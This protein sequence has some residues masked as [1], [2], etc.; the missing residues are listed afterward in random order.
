MQIAN[1]YFFRF[2]SFQPKDIT[3]KIYNNPNIYF[4]IL[5]NN[6]KNPEK[7]AE[8]TVKNDRSY[9]ELRVKFN[10]YLLSFGARVDKGLDRFY[11]VNKNRMPSTMRRYVES[12]D[13][14]TKITPLEAQKRAF[15]ALEGAKSV[16][17][18]K[19]AFPDE[20]LFKNLINPLESKAKRGI[21][22]S[23]KENSELLALSGQ[24]VL[25]NGENLTVYL[26]K[27]VFLEAKSIEEINHDLEN[28]LDSDFKADFKFT[29]P[30]SPFIYGTTLKALGIKVPEFEYQQSLRYTK[31]GYSETVGEKISQGQRA[32]WDSL[33]ATERT[34]RAKKSVEKFEIWWNSH[35]KNEILEMLADQMSEL[36]ML[37]DYKKFQKA[38]ENP[39][40]QAISST[41]S[42]KNEKISKTSTKVGSNRLSQ[43]ELF[44]KWAANNLKIWLS[45]MSEADKDSLHIKRMQ[46]MVSRWAGM[47]ADERT[48]YISK[49]KSGSEPLRYTMI[50]AWNHSADLI[51]DL[52]FFLK[53]KQILKPADLLYSTQEFSRFQ[54]EIMTEFWENNPD[55]A[56]NLGQNIKKSQE[57]IQQSISNGTFEE[58][59]KQI[60]RD[61]NQRIKEMEKFKKDFSITAQT[62]DIAEKPQYQKDFEAAYNG[63]VFGKLKSIPKNFYNDMYKK[64]F[65]LLPENVI[66]LWTKNL[67]G[68]ALAPEEEILIKKFILNEPPEIARFNRALEAAF[69]DTL[70]SFTKNPDVYLMS[71]SDVKIAMYHLERGDEPIVLDSHKT[72]KRF[73][74]NIVK[75]NKSVDSARINSLYEYYKQDLSE[76]EIEKIIND[77]YPVVST[78]ALLKILKDLHLPPETNVTNGTKEL[79]KNY[80]KEY[81]RSLL[82]VFSEKSSYPAPVKEAFYNKFKANMP[83]FVDM[84]ESLF[85]NPNQ[86]KIDARLRHLAFMLEKKYDFVPDSFMKDYADE[87]IVKMR[88]AKDTDTLDKFENQYLIKRKTP[89]DRGCIALVNKDDFSVPNKLKCLAMEQALADVLFD[90]TGDKRVFGLQFEELCDNIEVFRLVSDKNIPSE[91]RTYYS[92]SLGDSIS[93]HLNKKLK[94]HRLNVLFQHYL[95]EIKIWI[96][97]DVK[98]EGKGYFVDLLGILNPDE[99]DSEKDEAISHRMDEYSLNL[100]K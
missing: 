36:D 16:E 53:S 18:I 66:K 73:V 40:K 30:D 95:E 28:D 97:N 47:T 94:L 88:A 81:C 96:N 76:S 20:E 1:S 45:N 41:Q 61:K 67:R 5:N 57:K 34:A 2:S 17:D 74:L 52:S 11:E 38:Q 19:E 72:G 86:F 32:F 8:K 46:R 92:S 13:D 7:R 83:K 80:M 90:A 69:A 93:L 25:K 64:L 68:E 98:E 75:K 79:L 23:A 31:A 43:D 26:V 39:Q 50:D 91:E 62:V 12:L 22:Q 55:Y 56:L 6:P 60:M 21:L 29:N 59:K 77:Y 37:K 10:D 14:K 99:S 49:M 15:I 78:G 35:T 24:D 89:W 42:P 87:F 82:V 54:S 51:K 3:M 71:N 9:G 58:L 84:P 63:H 48:D 65:E 70:Y 4:N 27:K 85:D 44:K 33:E 100:V